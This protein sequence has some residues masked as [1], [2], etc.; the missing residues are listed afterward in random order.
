MEETPGEG[1]INGD[2]KMSDRNGISPYA[3]S[4]V[5]LC[6]C[7]SRD[8]AS[9]SSDPYSWG[10]V[11]SGGHALSH[12]LRGLLYEEMD[13]SGD[14]VHEYERFLERWADAEEGL[15][16]LADARNMLAGLQRS[17]D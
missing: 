3:I 16:Q 7:R 11:F 9:S 14:A 15:P 2:P 6:S 1:V 4:A 12:Y 17:C 5:H 13:Q 8:P 10:S